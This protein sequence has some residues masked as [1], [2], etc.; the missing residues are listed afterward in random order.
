MKGEGLGLMGGKKEKIRKIFS[1]LKMIMS[2]Q[3]LFLIDHFRHRLVNPL[4][5]SAITASHQNPKSPPHLGDGLWQQLAVLF[6]LGG[7][8]G[9]KAFLFRV[10]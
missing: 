1:Y 3:Y 6:W 4:K 7:Y 2:P 10:D 8:V 5:R 9:I